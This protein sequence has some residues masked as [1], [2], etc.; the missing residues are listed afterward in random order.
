MSYII[1]RIYSF[2]CDHA[3]CT[4]VEEYGG[5]FIEDAMKELR[6][7]GWTIRTE[8]V[9]GITVKTRRVRKHYCPDHNPEPAPKAD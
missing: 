1:I 2:E 7:A 3:T 6:T 8:R 9:P 4:R 5:P